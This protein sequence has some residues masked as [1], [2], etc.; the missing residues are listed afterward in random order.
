MNDRI[1]HNS[2]IRNDLLDAG[3]DVRWSLNNRIVVS[4][5][6]RVSINE[7]RTALC[8]AGY[9]EE[10]FTINVNGRWVI[11]DAV[12]TL[13][14]GQCKVTTKTVRSVLT[15]GIDDGI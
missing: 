5:N 7:V 15:E 1:S 9:E 8:N 2:L 6:R 3:F 12:G 4:L 14:Q 10:T 11:V 13:D